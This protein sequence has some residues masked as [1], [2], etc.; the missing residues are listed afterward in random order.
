M[1]RV[2]NG[3]KDNLMRDEWRNLPDALTCLDGTV[4][5]DRKQWE[6][7]RRPEI[8]EM[9]YQMEYGRIPEEELQVTIRLT[10]VAESPDIMGGK[11]L[12]KTIEVETERKGRQFSFGFVIFVPKRKSKVPVFITICNRGI[13]DSDPSRDF[14][15]S[16]WPAE[17]IV[18]R[19]YGAAAFR[20]QE[21]APDYDEVFTTG[22][23]RLFP[24]YG[25]RGKERPA[26]LYGAISAW[27]WAVSRIIDYIETDPDL[28]EKRIAVAGHSRG[29]K[30]AL[31]TAA[32]D[33]RVAMAAASCA[34]NSGDAL[35]RGSRGER[36]ENIT[37]KF[38]YWFCPAYKTFS[39]REEE[40]PFDQHML[41]GLIA[42][43]L[44]YT[45]A[46]SRDDWADPE[47]QFCSLLQAEKVY[48]LYGKTGLEEG[49]FQSPEEPLA[50]GAIGHHLKTGSHDLDEYDWNC[51]LDF[52]D[53]YLVPFL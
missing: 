19:G 5:R 40:L 24:E 50:G 23:H 38:P 9:F 49:S 51:Y 14:L 35:S 11:A 2:Q 37:G 13:K 17:T 43:R 46:R 10:D 18:S 39:G 6:G 41:L 34:G 48:K 47:G 15:S 44:L 30:T 36:I 1:K 4:I 16:F 21:V 12:R 32:R 31:W 29:G 22:F 53:Q 42:P 28:D 25:G 52:A 8:L 20:S 26:N 3:G 7:K 33:P 27:S 45:S